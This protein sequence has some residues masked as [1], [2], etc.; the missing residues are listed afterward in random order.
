MD[1]N[2]VLS[3]IPFSWTGYVVACSKKTFSLL[4]Y[5]GAPWWALAAPRIA[6]GVPRILPLVEA[7]NLVYLGPRKGVLGE[8]MDAGKAT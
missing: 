4:S 6:V 1:T 2:R 8:K 3:R 5:A 7:G